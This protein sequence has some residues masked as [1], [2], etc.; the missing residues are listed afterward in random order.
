MPP[1]LPAHVAPCV[2][3]FLG[4]DEC[5]GGHMPFDAWPGLGGRGTE[6]ASWHQGS[7]LVATQP[8]CSKAV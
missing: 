3:V 5:L 8:L 6:P 4:V 1:A 2:T 7:T